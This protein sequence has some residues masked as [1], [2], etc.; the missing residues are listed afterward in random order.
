MRT[1]FEMKRAAVLIGLIG[2]AGA[3]C[4]D[5]PKPAIPS[6]KKSPPAA[7]PSDTQAQL[8]ESLT[9]AIEGAEMLLKISPTDKDA[10]LAAAL[11]A[12][13]LGRTA[14]AIQ[15]YTRLQIISQETE[16]LQKLAELQIE[17][18]PD[19][20]ARQASKFFE[21]GG[22]DD[23]LKTW[24]IRDR[25]RRGDHRQA[26]LLTEGLPPPSDRAAR[27]FLRDLCL[28][29]AQALP[30]SSSF[31]ALTAL[32]RAANFAP[33]PTNLAETVALTFLSAGD[34][35]AARDVLKPHAGPAHLLRARIAEKLDEPQE[36]L[37][38]RLKYYYSGGSDPKELFVL[39]EQL[40]R[41]PPARQ[42]AD[43]LW[44]A[45]GLDLRSRLS[46][47]NRLAQF[48]RESPDTPAELRFLEEAKELGEP[49]ILDRL[50]DLQRA[51]G[52][53][54]AALAALRSRYPRVIPD[55]KIDLY[56]TQALSAG[57]AQEALR[58][59]EQAT[60]A[61]LSQTT[62][63]RL[64]D[65]LSAAAEGDL[66]AG[67]I[68]SARS[69]ALRADRFWPDLRNQKLLAK[70]SITEGDTA[71]ALARLTAA[72][73]LSVGDPEANYLA[74][75]IL[76]HQKRGSEAKTHLQMA[77]TSRY[78][79]EDLPLMLGQIHF[80]EKSMPMA[81]PLLKEYVEG[82]PAR[83]SA[84]ILELLARAAMVS[85]HPLDA[86]VWFERRL[87]MGD[88]ER[89]SAELLEALLSAGQG[90][91]A[92]GAARTAVA[93]YPSSKP[94]L[95][96]AS[97][98]FDLSID[99]AALLKTLESLASIET[100]PDKKT[101]ILRRLLDVKVRMGRTAEADALVTQLFERY[102]NDAQLLTI[103]WNL[104][105]GTAAAEPILQRLANIRAPGDPIQLIRARQLLD[106]KNYSAALSGVREYLAVRRDDPDGLAL[107]AEIHSRMGNADLAAA[108]NRALL[109][110]RKDESARLWLIQYAY[111]Q[112]FA[113]L[114]GGNP[115]LNA[116][117]L[118]AEAV[119][120]LGADEK[121]RDLYEVFGKVLGREGRTRGRAIDAYQ[122]ELRLTK[123]P[124]KRMQLT[125]TLGRW[126]LDDGQ[127]AL[128]K[129]MLESSQSSGNTAPE[130]LRSYA[131]LLARLGELES[132]DERYRMLLKQS[133]YDREANLYMA[134]RAVDLGRREDAVKSLE[135]LRT[136]SPADSAVLDALGSAYVSVKRHVE[137]AR[138]WKILLDRTAAVKYSG[139]YADALYESGQFSLALSEYR[140]VRAA[141]LATAA[142]LRR[143]AEL[144]QGQGNWSE[145]E[146]IM[147]SLLRM[148]GTDKD[149]SELSELLR[150]LGGRAVR[151][152]NVV[153]AARTAER[154][155]A[156]N[157]NDPAAFL[158]MG[159]AKVLEGKTQAALESFS[160]ARSLAPNDPRAILG[161]AEVE[162]RQNRHVAAIDY[163]RKALTIDPS[164]PEAHT[165]IGLAYQKTGDVKSAYES[166]KNAIL[167]SKN[168][169]IAHV[170][171][172]DLFLQHGKY[173]V[174]LEQYR[175]ALTADP[176]NAAA[177]LRNAVALHKLG[178]SESAM[179]ELLTVMELDPA[180]A[181]A[182]A[183][184]LLS[185][186]FAAHGD[187]D[188]ARELLESAAVTSP[189]ASPTVL[190]RLGEISR[191]NGEHEKS[192][193]L[194]RDALLRSADPAFRY[195]VLNALGLSL[196]AL[197]EGD[198]AE[199]T[200][201]EASLLDPRRPDAFLNLSLLHRGRK[202]FL[203]AVDAARKAIGANP[204]NPE[205]Y[206]LMG[207]IY[208]ESGWQKESLAAFRESLR[209]RPDQP[210]IANLVQ[211]I[212]SA[213]A[214]EAAE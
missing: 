207:L 163:A 182:E 79:Q 199:K 60:L 208:Y 15:Y 22:S 120:L 42:V 114:A 34:A 147:M 105:K 96:A 44:R 197:G 112:A 88:D 66:S 169:A 64:A 63:R 43:Q 177:H 31:D 167:N 125:E 136:A 68:S 73:K 166:F 25:V 8:R 92:L 150:R 13:H 155:L 148:G 95:E 210:E 131:R 108:A 184:V 123:D 59:S 134:R 72:L 9:Q 7:V 186:I 204:N 94:I 103:A 14:Q 83:A 173:N 149:R 101:R 180:G 74:G 36:A 84:E 188:R 139:R 75:K 206:K 159:R 212:E 142:Q 140:T 20:A 33:L 107:Q 117:S 145:A 26:F 98:V 205:G 71:A 200:L 168:R 160:R 97:N 124:K 172:G 46:I 86:A 185:E 132:S 175:Q 85:G 41:S 2:A 89:I 165:L 174:A 135:A 10:L 115:L 80:S 118:F 49:A 38:Q 154:L 183:K 102:P 202:N 195:E 129:E 128:A 87:A 146:E 164:L 116:E 137:A 179:K 152:G 65:L 119:A 21:Q 69:A 5:S 162:F 6:A 158:L 178:F 213:E 151:Q 23:R 4:G 138:V 211:S 191:R 157:P 106:D 198:A 48:Y 209:L 78:P 126:Y 37:A 130:F 12:E 176:K 50:A 11:A 143:L 51:L 201:K 57:E 55:N 133:P 27:E 192:V 100:D 30:S 67:Q 194:F 113:A 156:L 196:A 171:M 45:K 77:Y 76:F 190:F 61:A 47:S 161:L 141:G 70:I 35:R 18:N 203:A 189:A 3:G 82:K 56:V 58:V 153:D 214:E 16:Y 193:R 53:A 187:V 121:F 93:K 40:G 17:S 19:A 54:R 52:N 90:A 99:S 111:D 122:R 110:I 62:R 28:R 29:Q 32:R 109:K 181:G 39:L 24:L 91:K 81:Y 127:L 104:R 170:R 1:P 144:E